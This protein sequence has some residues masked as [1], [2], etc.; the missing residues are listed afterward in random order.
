MKTGAT[1]HGCLRASQRIPFC[2]GL[3]FLISGCARTPQ[4]MQHT[5]N[6]AT[7]FEI[8]Q[9]VADDPETKAYAAAHL[10]SRGIAVL[11]DAMP[12]SLEACGPSGNRFKFARLSSPSFDSRSDFVAID[13]LYFDADAA[14]LEI[15][16]PPT[17][18]NG[19]FFLRRKAG[20]WVIAEK[21]L[22]E[23]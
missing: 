18:K 11:W 23:S 22:W 5:G 14:F 15:S 1:V 6:C 8:L 19:D 2:L 12:P 7:P 10:E 3:A 17:G 13:K 21:T 4:S 9:A 16:F 20:K